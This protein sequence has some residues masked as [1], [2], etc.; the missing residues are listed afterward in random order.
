MLTEEQRKIVEEHMNI[1][2]TYC[3]QKRIWDEDIV[4][5]MMLTYVDAMQ[6][7]DPSRNCK[8]ST[9]V[10]NCLD[11]GMKM[12]Y[13]KN[14]AMKRTAEVI[15]LDY[16][17]FNSVDG[18]AT[19]LWAMLDDGKDYI[20][21]IIEKDY[22]EKCLQYAKETVNDRD[23]KVFIDYVRGARQQDLAVK[24]N[25][26]HSSIVRIIQAVRNKMRK[27]VQA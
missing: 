8:I 24:Y 10:Y 18:G 14:G 15:S 27:G 3:N 17:V 19:P 9:Y 20:N 22:V 2:Y 11:N 23:F 4:A 21:Y 26:C 7:F 25:L 13:R 5:E 6:N 12:F 1:V 16:E